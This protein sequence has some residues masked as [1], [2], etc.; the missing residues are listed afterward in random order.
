[1]IIFK[2]KTWQALSG[3]PNDNWL[4]DSDVEQPL[5]VVDDNSNIARKIRQYRDFELVIEDGQIVD[6]KQVKTIEEL[7]LELADTDYKVIKCMEYQ[8]TGLES[9]YDIKK[10]NE[11]RQSIRDSINAMEEKK[12]ENNGDKL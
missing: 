4:S 5:Y 3:H 7:K 8:L 1:M 11:N 2:D 12:G 6:V 9:P 10:L